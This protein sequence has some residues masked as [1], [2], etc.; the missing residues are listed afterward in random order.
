MPESECK[1][2]TTV[3][4]GPTH[5]PWLLLSAL[6]FGVQLSTDLGIFWMLC[7]AIL[8]TVSILEQR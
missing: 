2:M 5:V 6:E 4:D 8:A 3:S 7:P 1:S